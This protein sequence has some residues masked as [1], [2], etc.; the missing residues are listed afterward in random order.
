MGTVLLYDGD[1]YTVNELY[2]YEISTNKM[3]PINLPGEDERK[4]NDSE[5]HIIVVQ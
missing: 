2:F 1:G 3:I 5:K 4:D